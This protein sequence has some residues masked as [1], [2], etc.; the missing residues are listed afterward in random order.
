MAVAV[1][2]GIGAGLLNGNRRE[3]INHAMSLTGEVGLALAGIHLEVQGEENLWVRRPAVFAFN[4]QSQLDVLIM[5]RLLRENFTGIAKAHTRNV[6]GFGP[7]FQFAGVA[8]VEPGEK[9]RNREAVAPAVDRLKDGLSLA[10]APEGTRTPTPRLAPFKKGAF[11][12]AMQAGVPVVP[13]VIRAAGALMRRGEKLLRAGTVQV[14]V[15]PPIPTTRWTKASMAKQVESVR[16]QFVETLTNWPAAGG[17]KSRKEPRR[18]P[19]AGKARRRS[20]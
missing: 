2:I 12:I 8:F 9:E 6:P 20:R 10:V 3:A 7:F 15:L 1:A 18:R 13:V 11:Y 16:D 14:V 19:V 5:L 17:A 4:H